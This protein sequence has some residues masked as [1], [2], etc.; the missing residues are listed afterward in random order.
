MTYALLGIFAVCWLFVIWRFYRAA[1]YFSD[2]SLQRA[3][4]ARRSQES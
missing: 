3:L 2:R 1:E 4:E